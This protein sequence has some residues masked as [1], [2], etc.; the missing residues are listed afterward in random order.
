MN[1]KLLMFIVTL[2]LTSLIMLSFESKQQCM[3]LLLLPNDMCFPLPN[4]CGD[5]DFIF[6]LKI[7][8]Q[9]NHCFAFM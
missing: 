9:N 1:Q 5:T 3:N 4:L 8:L 7:T 6:S 2:T